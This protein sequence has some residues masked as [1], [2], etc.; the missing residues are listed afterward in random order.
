LTADR[1][2]RYEGQE[3][4]FWCG[5]DG[6]WR[7]VWI[8]DDPP[9]ASKVGVLKAGCRGPFWGIAKYAEY[10]Q[11]DRHGNPVSMWRKMPANQLAKCAEALALRKAFPQELSNL[12]T[13]DEMGQADR[14]ADPPPVVNI[15]ATEQARPQT[16]QEA[17][18]RPGARFGE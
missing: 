12:Y 16:N 10:V 5:A 6:A 17:P 15:A 13:L 18:A 1:S 14:D 3:G 9:A 7:D 4:P 11:T 2:G 8:G